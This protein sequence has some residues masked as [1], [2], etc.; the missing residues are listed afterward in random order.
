M[1]QG[2]GGVPTPVNIHGAIALHP[3]GSV[4]VT[5]E[6]I[7]PPGNVS[8]I[9]TV[10]CFE[11]S[12]ALRWTFG[13]GPINCD[14]ESRPTPAVDSDLNRVYVGTGSGHI[15]A[16]NTAVTASGIPTVAWQFPPT[17]ST[18]LVGAFRAQLAFDSTQVYAHCND[19]K[20]YVLNR[21]TGVLVKTW[22]TGNNGPTGSGWDPKPL[23]SGAAISADGVVFV[24]TA[25]TLNS[26]SGLQTG[27]LLGFDPSAPGT[28]AP[29][30]AVSLGVAIEG[31]PSIGPNCWV[32][33][34]SRNCD[35]ADTSSVAS[36]ANHPFEAKVFVIDPTVSPAPTTPLFSNWVLRDHFSADGAGPGAIFGVTIDRFGYVYVSD[37][38]HMITRFTPTL[39]RLD[40]IH[41][42]GKLCQTPALTHGGRLL[43]AESDPSSGNTDARS[44]TALALYPIP[45]STAN[46]AWGAKIGEAA[47][48]YSDL[49]VDTPGRTINLPPS[50]LLGAPLN[51]FPH[52]TI[53]WR[54]KS[55]NVTPIAPASSF[56]W[57]PNQ[58]GGVAVAADGGIWTADAGG[59]T[60]GD[61]PGGHLVRISGSSPLMG[62]SW[63]SLQGG[64]RR[65]GAFAAVSE[66][67]IAELANFISSTG[68]QDV[69]A[70]HPSGYAVGMSE[71]YYNYP[72][73][74]YQRAATVWSGTVPTALLGS[75]GSPAPWVPSTASGL[76]LLGDVVGWKESA[77]LPLVWENTLGTSAFLVQLPTEPGSSLTRT[78]GIN[79]SKAVVGYGAVAGVNRVYRW[80]KTGG[81]WGI[82]SVPLSGGYA[83][84]TAG[85]T[86]AGRIFGRAKFGG[87]NWKGYYSQPSP[88]TLNV[89]SQLSDFGGGQSEVLAGLDGY[90]VIGRSLDSS[91]R[92]RA[93]FVKGDLS[94]SLTLA[95]GDQLP[96]LLPSG[97]ANTSRARGINRSCAVV[98][99]ATDNFNTGVLHAF[100]WAPNRSTLVNLQTFVIGSQLALSSAAA[101]CDGGTIVGTG[102]SGSIPRNWI[103]YPV[104]KTN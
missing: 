4:Y 76:N 14:H 5:T 20:L 36:D 88:S 78:V 84:E 34:A 91:G 100:V 33:V 95:A 75:S 72:N 80:I 55:A 38:S 28:A 92:W 89:V 70:V 47:V 68:S 21:T 16:L 11:A 17:G 42:P 29:K 90:G 82:V 94:Q 103:A 24:G 50:P 30:F 52:A 35:F 31:P 12:G 81:S 15:F 65:S 66:Y 98:G 37:F 9:P 3:D 64:N 32:Y 62:G 41:L 23:S 10:Q 6:E 83:A 101:I 56:A 22:T 27:R 93:F 99:E 8:V 19:G 79:D 77:N 60:S 73:A 48:D 49:F 58:F 102:T 46:G 71:G 67:I 54:V 13:L 86:S 57:A 26:N 51:T 39:D 1:V 104:Y 18:L 43:V 40:A 96:P 63:T 25:E 87:G 74:A 53:A 97:S 2:P 7:V 61:V 59:M 85:I 45:T 44:V 69:T